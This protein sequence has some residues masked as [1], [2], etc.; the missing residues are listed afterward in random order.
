MLNLYSSE[1]DT[2][3]SDN[4]KKRRVRQGCRT[5][6]IMV[7]SR[8]KLLKRFKICLIVG[9]IGAVLLGAVNIVMPIIAGEFTIEAVL[10]F[11]L[12]FITCAVVFPLQLVGFTIN[13]TFKKMVI[14]MIAPIPV[15]S[16]MI[17]SVKAFYYGIRAAIVVLKGQDA[18]VIGTPV[19]EDDTNCGE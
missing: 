13:H 9:I 4:I 5:T 17:E 10:Y 3:G 1:F 7:Y 8:E 15:I 11:V 19:I 16:G 12:I 2:I 14:G 18:L 6:N